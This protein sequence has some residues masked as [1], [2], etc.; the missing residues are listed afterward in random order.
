MTPGRRKVLET[1][2]GGHELAFIFDYR[3]NPPT[4]ARVYRADICRFNAC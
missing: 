4:P 3:V 2:L 1:G